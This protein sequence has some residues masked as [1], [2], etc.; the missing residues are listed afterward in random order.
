MDGICVVY[1]C[2]RPAHVEGM[3]QTHCEQAGVLGGPMFINPKRKLADG[4]V[5]YLGLSL[6]LECARRIERLAEETGVA[7]NQLIVDIVEGWAMRRRAAQ[8]R[9]Q[10]H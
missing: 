6:P 2:G 3:C 10:L 5:E 4:R 1:S 7:A 9:M 8:V